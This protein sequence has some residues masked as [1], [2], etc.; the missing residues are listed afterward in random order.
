MEAELIQLAM[1]LLAYAMKDP[2]GP[3]TAGAALALVG[4]V[5]FKGPLK[6]RVNAVLTTDARKR[7]ALAAMAIIPAVVAVLSEAATWN[8]A[9]GTSLLSALVSQGVF[10][11]VKNASNKLPPAG[12]GMVGLVLLLC[13]P[14]AVVGCAGAQKQL[15]Q[16]QQL[17]E[18]GRDVAAVAE[19]CL[20]AQR[21]LALKECEGNLECERKVG[22]VYDKIGGQLNAMHDIWCQLLPSGEGCS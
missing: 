20:A 15:E 3:V 19:P 5:L 1:T 17:A 13:L 18:A 22:E 8:K 21:E 9:L 2:F 11:L 4:F 14:G 7:V 6:D 12:G 10:F 16:V